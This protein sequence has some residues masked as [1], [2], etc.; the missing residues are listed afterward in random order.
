MADALRVHILDTGHSLASEGMLLRGGGRGKV[1]C[2]CLVALLRHP[3]EGWVLWDTGYSP[4]M[5]EETRRLPYRLYRS[6]TPL[7]LR[8]ELAVAAQL[9]RLGLAVEDVRTVLLS[10]FHADHLCGVRDF[11]H[12]RF[13]ATEPAWS[14]VAK[15]SGWRA[16]RRAFIPALLPPDFE[17]R[18]TRI[19]LPD[20]P[21][22]EGPGPAHDLF[23][24][25]SL[26]LVSLPGHAAGHVGLLARTERGPMLLAGDGAW[27]RRAV[28]ERR[29]P[30]PATHLFL[31]DPTAARETLERLHAFHRRRPDV[32]LV[33]THCPEAC[34]ELA[35]P[36][37]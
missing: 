5:L 17:A 22:W 32:L 31:D 35:E 16:L 20:G 27:L 9:P 1:E 30:H 8:P 28:R 24:D 36:L 6:A 25:G 10:H 23:G 12:A 34:A 21:S 29:P 4:R 33:P 14:S 13:I 15:L 26:L 2:H 19:P 18:L 11:P 3:R 7:R 37:P